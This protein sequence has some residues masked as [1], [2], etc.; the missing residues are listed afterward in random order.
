MLRSSFILALLLWPNFAVAGEPSSI[1][2]VETLRRGDVLTVSDLLIPKGVSDSV[3]QDYVGM[4]TIRTIYAGSAIRSRDVRTPLLVKR[5]ARVSMIYRFGGLE[6]RA[7]GR[8]LAPGGQGDLIEVL[9][10]ESRKR[11]EGRIIG[12]N[13]IEMQP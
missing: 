3:L 5:N 10:L 11:I 2:A 1:T 13:M 12:A 9:N 6:I 8:A 4:E 7:V